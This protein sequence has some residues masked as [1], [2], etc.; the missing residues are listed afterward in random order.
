MV[1]EVGP[2]EH[3]VG[4]EERRGVGVER[5][6]PRLHDVVAVLVE[7]GGGRGHADRFEGS[8]AQRQQA[9]LVQGVLNRD[10]VTGGENDVDAPALAARLPT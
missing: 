4:L 6:A 1:A 2:A 9:P 8:L 7:G 3:A 5:F 10:E